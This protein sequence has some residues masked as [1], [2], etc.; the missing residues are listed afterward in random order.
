MIFAAEWPIMLSRVTTDQSRESF[1][2]WTAL[3]DRIRVTLHFKV[4]I[5]IFE[6]NFKYFCTLY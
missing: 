6:T 2:H 1:V 3:F 4:Q 5:L